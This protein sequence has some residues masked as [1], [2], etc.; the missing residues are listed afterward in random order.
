MHLHYL[1]SKY[2]LMTFRRLHRVFIVEKKT[3]QFGKLKLIQ[4]APLNG[5][6]RLMES[7]LSNPRLASAIIVAVSYRSSDFN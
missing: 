5:I 7:N 2:L 3:E 6:S 4:W 1:Y